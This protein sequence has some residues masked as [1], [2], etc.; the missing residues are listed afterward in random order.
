MSLKEEEKRKNI[1]FIIGFLITYVI[2][3]VSN[4]IYFYI[5]AL[6]ESGPHPIYYLSVVGLNI[7]L[8]IIAVKV[9]NKYPYLSMGLIVASLGLLFHKIITKNL[10]SSGDPYV[11]NPRKKIFHF[12]FG[13]VFSFC[14]LVLHLPY[15]IIMGFFFSEPGFIV[16]IISIFLLNIF[17][18]VT[19]FFYK[20]NL[21]SI[22]K[23]TIVAILL[24]LGLII[25]DA[26]MLLVG[27]N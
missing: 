17:I 23:G 11:E 21:R 5:R 4:L 26:Y 20:A 15:F 8:C 7:I 6:E 1:Q 2:F 18:G 3:D 22:A 16:F 9:Q 27:I 14:L 13:I 12:I 25:I 24:L 19:T 10:T